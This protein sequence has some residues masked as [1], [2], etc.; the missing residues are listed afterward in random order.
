MVP[1]LDAL[2]HPRIRF[3]IAL[4]GGTSD[5]FH[6]TPYLAVPVQ[7]F[8][9]RGHEHH[10]HPAAVAGGHVGTDLDA[11]GGERDS[12]CHYRD[13]EYGIHYDSFSVWLFRMWAAAWIAW[14]NG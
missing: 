1:I 9:H 14:R 3:F 6:A 8:H 13:D 5:F 10:G 2:Y 11:Q 4:V 7:V 12:D